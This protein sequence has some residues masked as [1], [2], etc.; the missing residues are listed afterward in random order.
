MA[1]TL[2]KNKA[3]GSVVKLNEYGSPV[4]FVLKKHNY[5]SDLNGNGRSLLVRKIAQE[6]IYDSSH[7]SYR[8]RYD[9]CAK[10]NYLNTTYKQSLDPDIQ[11]AIS[12][13]QF[14]IVDSA[15]KFN[16]SISAIEVTTTTTR[17]SVFELSAT[18]LGGK[19]LGHAYGDVGSVLPSYTSLW[20]ATNESGEHIHQ[21]TRTPSFT[22]DQSGLNQGEFYIQEGNNAPTFVIRVSERYIRPCFTLPDTALV[23]DDG[24]IVINSSPVISGSDSNLGIFSA[25]GPSISYTVTDE[26]DDPVTV[27]IKV[28][29]VVIKTHA[30]TLGQSNAFQFSSEDWRK[31]LNGEHTLKIVADDS[32]IPSERTY[33]FT[34]SMTSMS[35]TLAEPLPADDVITK[36]IESIIGELPTGAAVKIEVCNNGYDDSPTW[37]DVTQRVLAGEKF[38]LTNATKTAENW[39]YNVRVTVSRGSA[40][41]DIYINSMG[42]F[43]E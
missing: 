10:C 27:T 33:T 22:N 19:N 42:G 41:G 29:G 14:Y 16:S 17:K 38:Q 5:E 35:F 13:T 26:D 20:D 7:G 21:L 18:E 24:T 15:V 28:D 8:A 34:K 23:L 43:F 36:A 4:E 37:Q 1:A 32:Y 12:T 31:V 39:G 40:T 30:V 6:Y 25:S 3:E 11:A 2:I 9:T